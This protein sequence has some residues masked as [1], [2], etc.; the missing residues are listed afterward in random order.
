MDNIDEFI[1][2]LKSNHNFHERKARELKLDPKRAAKH[3]QT[4]E[5]LQQIADWF[6]DYLASPSQPYPNSDTSANASVEDLFSLNP[7]EIDQLPEDFRN[8]ISISESDRQDAQVIELLRLANRPLDLNEL[9][10]GCWRKFGIQYKRNQLTARLYRVSK[11]GDIYV[12][13]KGTYSIHPDPNEVTADTDAV[14]NT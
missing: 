8:E 11:R 2:F 9:L 12:V 1:K 13:G 4:A 7:L 10:I 3:S 6:E 5:G 14:T